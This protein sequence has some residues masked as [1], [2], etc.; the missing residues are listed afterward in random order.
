MRM[1]ESLVD[2]AVYLFVALWPY[3]SVFCIP[4][5]VVVARVVGPGIAMNTGR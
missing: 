1:M 3:W 2:V 4:E 5:L